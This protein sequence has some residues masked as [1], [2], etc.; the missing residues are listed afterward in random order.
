MSKQDE[1]S[2]PEGPTLEE[3][4]LMIEKL[5]LSKV[6]EFRL[7]GYENI[8]GKEI[9]DCVSEKYKYSQVPRLHRIVNDILTL[10][11]TTFMNWL[12]LNAMKDI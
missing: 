10:K 11:S 3:L 9:W 7:L 12:S 6:E 2:N 5:C 8:S 1:R 4:N